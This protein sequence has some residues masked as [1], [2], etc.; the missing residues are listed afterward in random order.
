VRDETRARVQ[1][2]IDELGYR[3]NLTARQLRQGRTGMI[4]LA[5][6]DLTVPYFAEL[7]G[8]VLQAAER[9]GLTLLIEQTAGSRDR[10][11]MLAQGPRSK[12][13]DGLLLSPLAAGA[14]DLP[15]GSEAVPLVLLGERIYDPRFDHVAIDNVAAAKAATLHLLASGRRRIAALGVASGTR[16]SMADLRLRGY[17]EAMAEYGVGVDEALVVPT[18]WFHRS[19]GYLAAQHLLASGPPPEGMFCFNDLIAHGALRALAEAGVRCPDDVAVVG[20]DDIEENQ[21]TVPS[22]TSIAPDK[23]QLA[24]HAVNLLVRRIDGEGTDGVDDTPGFSLSV[25]ESAP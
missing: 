25:R 20:I 3:P 4:A 21:Y 23:V 1:A 8:H 19:D 24:Q 13:I 2:A 12:T 10:E 7:A 15:T 5:V 6:P 9:R 14:D 18:T 16:S 22:L 11:V 17:R